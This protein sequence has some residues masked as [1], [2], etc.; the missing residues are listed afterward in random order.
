MLQ[1]SKASALCVCFSLFS[2]FAAAQSNIGLPLL[3]SLQSYGPDTINLANLNAFISIPVVHKADPGL[4]FSFSLD[5]NSTVLSPSCT[6]KNNV[7]TCKWARTSDWNE[8]MGYQVFGSLT[9]TTIINGA[10]I[11]YDYTYSDPTG[12]VHQFPGIL[13]GPSGGGCGPQTATVYATDGSGYSITKIYG[14]S[15]TLYDI[16]GNVIVAKPGFLPHSITDPNGNS[17]S[18]SDGLT[19]TD[20]TGMQVL[21]QSGSWGGT[22]PVT[23][24]YTGPSSTPETVTVNFSAYTLAT[25]FGCTTSIY[26]VP[27]GE[28][29]PTSVN[30]VSSISLPDNTNYTFKYEASGIGT[31]TTGR[32][33]EIDLP[34]GGS[35]Q[36]TYTGAN[37]GIDCNDGTAAGL[38]RTTLDGIWKY[39]RDSTFT[40]TTGQDPAGNQT[41]HQFYSS[42]GVLGTEVQRSV[43]NGSAI[44]ANL[45]ETDTTCYSTASAAPCTA[46]Q[47][48]T[49]G[50]S[51]AVT[52]TTQPVGGK[53]TQTVTY[54]G[55]SV[56][57][58]GGYVQTLDLPTE[59]DSYDFGATSPTY[60]KKITYAS[61]GANLLN[62]PACVQVTAG[63]NS[64]ACGTSNS[65]T[66]S[67]ILYTYDS[68]GN[69]KQ[70]S[71]W[72]TGTTSLVK[73]F[74]YFPNG[75]LQTITDVN[76]NPITYAYQTCGP[77]AVRA[78]V[79]SISSGGLTSSYAWDCN[80][81]VSTQVSDANAQP[82][83]YGYV[84]RSGT[85]DPFWRLNSVTDPLSNVTW[86][87]YTPA[88]SN[89]A[90]TVE[91]ALTFGSSTVDTLKTLDGLGRLV[92]SQRRMAPGALTFDNTVQYA[93]GW[94]T[95][96][97]VTGR[98]TTRT[99]PGGTALTTTQFDALGR[100][101]S[102]SD[103][104][105]GTLTLQYTQN[106]VLQTVGPTPVQQKQMEYDALGRITSVCEVT[107]GTAS[108][109]GGTCAQSS[110]QTGYWT[111]YTYDNPV[112]S[113]TVT[114]NAQA[115]TTQTR[116]YTYDGLGRLTSETNP[117]WNSLAT[118]YTYDTDTTCGTSNG[119]LVKKVDPAGNVICS[120]F[121]ALH[122]RTGSTYPS[123]PNSSVTAAKYFQY[124]S[125]Y[126]GSTGTNIK[127]RLVAAATCQSPTSCAGNSVTLEEFGY[128]ARGEL[129][130]IW[131]VTP[132]SAGT[133]HIQSS[134]WPN[135]QL[136]TLLGVS[137][138]TLT[139]GVDG[140]GRP[141]TV[142]ASAGVNP[143]SSTSYN[144]AGQVTD[145]TFGSSDPVHFG[146]D[147]NTGRMT[148]Y[149]FTIN[150]TAIHGDPKWNAN[151]TLGSLAITDPFNA[152]DAQTCNYGYD[153]LA[154]LASVDCGATIWQQNFIYDPFGNITKT[155]PP[156][157][158]GLTFQ[159][160]YNTATN[161]YTN[162]ATYDSNGNLTY[163]GTDHHYTWDADG[164]PVTLDS[165]SLVYDALGRE[166]EVLKSGAYT[167]FVFGPTGKM[168]LM[169]GQTQTKAFVPLPGGTQ[170]K[171]AGSSISTYRLPDWLG[172]FRVGS[173]PNRTYSWGIAFA[174]FG[175]QYATSGSP[176]LSFT[177]EQGTADTVN[178][179]YDFL[180]RKLHSAQGRWISPDPAGLGSVTL[181]NPQSWNRYAYVQNSPLTAVDTNG[182]ACYPIERN[183]TGSCG[184]WANLGGFQF[185]SQWSDFDIINAALSD[186]YEVPIWKGATANICADGDCVL[187][188]VPSG[189]ETVYP[190]IG[191][192]T[193]LSLS[194]LQGGGIGLTSRT[195]K[196]GPPQTA[197]EQANK[198]FVQCVT[199]NALSG[200]GKG[201]IETLFD[202]STGNEAPSTTTVVVNVA[203]AS[204]DVQKDCLSANPLADL[205][206][207]Y[208]G[209]FHAGD[210]GVNP[211]V[212]GM[213]PY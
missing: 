29:G 58:Q 80:G 195:N 11:T 63:T 35:I 201:L 60:V 7:T 110:S 33:S 5:Y 156:G 127:G 9:S 184:F 54:Y 109:P 68:L 94:T 96:G 166:A 162:G 40:K 53:S 202:S 15:T 108:W 145:V 118:A 75:L 116:S 77:N 136:N 186:S 210:P 1:F 102:V 46:L 194:T 43:Y 185:G 169:N 105:G 67:L 139:Y 151:G 103:G 137:L 163:D 198:G 84:S 89:T 69:L 181:A 61:L 192:L 52:V 161:R 207:N 6:T 209:L 22:N 18:T 119:D 133:Y 154:R 121:D 44:P 90:A 167:E 111:K 17:V 42:G 171:Y 114:Q 30:L 165:E 164:H 76:S 79:S 107:A 176:G 92:T 183:L 62:R 208:Q 27:I 65:K 125:E 112:N 175:E 149:K 93:Y 98:F 197:I 19:Y 160:G 170:V 168:A 2:F 193:L 25:N 23:Y 83:N 113:L 131:E 85:P 59:I 128:S 104:G 99:I 206:P 39:T 66:K 100:E 150:G 134:Y 177:G 142:S 8:E 26:G 158:T 143:V 16:S 20:T 190:H 205:S 56:T 191:L 10:C 180:A 21:A 144:S 212:G 38:N 153:D 141:S 101:A 203:D 37:K 115:S 147:P 12:A 24:T 106:D 55:L 138:P 189:F 157:G 196:D 211:I 117:E 47:G 140:E 213:I 97:P 124:D 173:N 91:T 45:L 70:S 123:G 129:T 178:D 74:S 3:G 126:F 132:H 120:T 13:V 14:V 187:T 88:T 87:T 64:S 57:G 32:L 72:A 48:T 148:Q 81:G 188:D 82:T 146:L 34:T 179:E 78:F 199:Q 155:V 172:S 159:P 122:R 73:S 4:N 41:V 51:G 182:L 95:S 135:G 50:I 174:P 36:F 152:S 200:V 49:G 28:L 31:D 71:T 204:L 86:T 130:D